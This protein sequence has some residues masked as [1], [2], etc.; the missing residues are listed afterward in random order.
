[1]TDPNDES[2]TAALGSADDL[3]R[4]R[5][6]PVGAGAAVAIMTDSGP[7]AYRN[8]CPHNGL[9]LDHAW[10]RDGVLTCPHHFW[11]FDVVTGRGLT[12]DDGLASLPIE[13]EGGEVHVTLPATGPAESFRERQLRHARSWRR[14]G[15]KEP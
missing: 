8:R 4:D 7:R 2:M 9:P 6:R 11:R 10:I 13:G 5:C 1:M 15:R 12:G 3:P 14:D